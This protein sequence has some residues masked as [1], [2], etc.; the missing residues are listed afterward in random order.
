MPLDCRWCTP[1]GKRQNPARMTM[2]VRRTHQC[3]LPLQSQPGG[4]DVMALPSQ[5][6]Y[7]APLCNMALLRS[8]TVHP[9]PLLHCTAPNNSHA[10]LGRTP[11]CAHGLQLGTSGSQ[12]SPV[13]YR[14]APMCT[15][16]GVL[17]GCCQV[18]HATQPLWTALPSPC[19]AGMHP[20]PAA[21][22]HA[23]MTSHLKR[24]CLSP[25]RLDFCCR[26]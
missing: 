19:F 20:C 2:Q 4:R 9:T 11:S 15:I 25:C 26:R 13:Q 23:A 7:P 17:H 8:A 6:R 14:P 16:C 22:F 21:Q 10:A 12:P 24:L 5:F 1:H 3:S 18:S